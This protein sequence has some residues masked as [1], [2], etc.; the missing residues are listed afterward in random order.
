MFENSDK[1]GSMRCAIRAHAQVRL[2]NGL[3]MEGESR[4][5]SLGGLLLSSEL[6]LPVG[7]PCRVSLVVEDDGEDFRIE[8]RGRVVRID[9]DG[10]AVEFSHLDIESRECL[11]RVVLNYLGVYDHPREEIHAAVAYPLA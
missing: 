9:E 10:L 4:N 11:R 8:M 1:R 3:M 2:E 7:N 5:V 6:M